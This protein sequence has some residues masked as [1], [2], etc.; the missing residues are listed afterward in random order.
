M[1]R[2]GARR[3]EMHGNTVR[4][5]DADQDAIGLAEFE[6]G[7]HTLFTRST[8]A[9]TGFISLSRLAT[10]TASPSTTEG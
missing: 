10:L 5:Q 1:L 6:S 3:D 2:P 8:K 4:R 9:A 7:G